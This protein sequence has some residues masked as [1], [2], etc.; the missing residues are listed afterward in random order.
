MIYAGMIYVTLELWAEK[1]K[2]IAQ[3][4]NETKLF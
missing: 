4:T 3:D 2:K 1:S